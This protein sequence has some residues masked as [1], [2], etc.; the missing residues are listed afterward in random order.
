M[1]LKDP[2][3]PTTSGTITDDVFK[4][5]SRCFTVKAEIKGCG[6]K[7]LFSLYDYVYCF[8]P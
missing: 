8:K 1:K 3:T 4:R 7:V 6:Q 5:I 2:K